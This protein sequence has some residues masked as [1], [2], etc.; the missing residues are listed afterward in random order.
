MQGVTAAKSISNVRAVQIAAEYGVQI[1]YSSTA[2]APHFRYQDGS[3][4][5]E[6][7][8]EDA[9]S[10]RT[11]LELVAEYGLRGA[12]YWNLMRPFPEN[13]SVLNALYRIEQPGF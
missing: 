12:G 10:I 2:Q 3:A 11:K 7:W 6:V 9:K 4:E 1:E 5:H 8:F 13:W